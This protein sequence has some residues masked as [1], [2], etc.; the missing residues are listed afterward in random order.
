[1]RLG[2]SVS[3]KVGGAVDRNR[4]K[5]ALREAFWSL[6]DSLPGGHD[7]VIVARPE[8]GNLIDRE[9]AT[10]ATIVAYALAS[11]LPISQ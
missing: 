11:G 6:T 5:R 8:I 7:F 1:M 2:V 3:R 9:G 4:V 10:G